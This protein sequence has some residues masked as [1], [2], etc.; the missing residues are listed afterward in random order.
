MTP[1][2]KKLIEDIDQLAIWLH[3]NPNTPMPSQY[4]QKAQVVLQKIINAEALSEQEWERLKPQVYKPNT[5]PK[6]KQNAKSVKQNAQKKLT[7]KKRKK[8]KKSF[9]PRAHIVRGGLPGLGKRR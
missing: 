7:S 8:R 9:Q 3:D 2:I 6:Q 1:A 4:K 5:L